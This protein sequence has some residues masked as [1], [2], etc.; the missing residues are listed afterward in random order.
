MSAQDI[1]KLMAHLRSGAGTNDKLSFVT[2]MVASS[3][4]V[5]GTLA[6]PSPHFSGVRP[7][8][9]SRHA[10]GCARATSVCNP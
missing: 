4:G 6:S 2:P 10:S 3:H 8:R 5:S 7:T 9:P 1:Q